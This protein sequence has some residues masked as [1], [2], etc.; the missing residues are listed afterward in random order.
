MAGTERFVVEVLNQFNYLPGLFYSFKTSGKTCSTKWGR[1][2]VMIILNNNIMMSTNRKA[3][4]KLV[5]LVEN[6]Y[7]T[8]F[9]SMISKRN[10]HNVYARK[11]KL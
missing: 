5:F 7:C 10:K 3:V 2:L 9:A 8:I 11:K 4:R 1:Y 6:F